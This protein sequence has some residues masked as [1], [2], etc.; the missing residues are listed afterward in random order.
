[1]FFVAVLIS[2]GRL[3]FSRHLV[4]LGNA[5]FDILKKKI[6]KNRL[7]KND[8][9]NHQQKNT[10]DPSK[11]SVRQWRVTNVELKRKIQLKS[12]IEKNSFPIKRIEDETG[13]MD[14][15]TSDHRRR[16]RRRE[17]ELELNPELEPELDPELEPET[18]L[19]PEPELDFFKHFGV[20]GRQ[21]GPEWFF[22]DWWLWHP[23]RL[24][25]RTS[26]QRQQDSGQARVP[27]SSQ[28]RPQQ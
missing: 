18:E 15:S 25:R 8:W 20:A 13:P 5:T 3:H 9:K 4:N 7:N 11:H 6:E 14:L 21:S 26:G 12:K 22:P 24:L 10:E 19:E 2:G 23:S 27:G 1:M 28:G 16:C 17:P